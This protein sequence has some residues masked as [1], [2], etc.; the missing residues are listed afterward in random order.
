MLMRL[1]EFPGRH[2]KGNKHV[3]VAFDL[4]DVPFPRPPVRFE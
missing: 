4:P 1:D 2:N 3:V